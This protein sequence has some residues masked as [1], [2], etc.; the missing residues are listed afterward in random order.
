MINWT[1]FVKKHLEGVNQPVSLFA[2][3][4]YHEVTFLVYV[5]QSEKLRRK[6]A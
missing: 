5:L 4:L 3:I 2:I 6:K 1:S